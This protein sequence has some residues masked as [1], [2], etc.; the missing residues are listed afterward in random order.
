[1]LICVNGATSFTSSNRYYIRSENIEIVQVS[2]QIPGNKRIFVI[3][4]N[5]NI[6][7]YPGSEKSLIDILKGENTNV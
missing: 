4:K 3:T 5:G 2:E 1:M 6:Y 7:H